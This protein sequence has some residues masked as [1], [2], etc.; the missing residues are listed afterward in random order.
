MNARHALPDSLVHTEEEEEGREEEETVEDT[1]ES[2]PEQRWT[3][4]TDNSGGVGALLGTVQ[5]SLC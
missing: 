4:H 1:S 2:P 3:A 5:A